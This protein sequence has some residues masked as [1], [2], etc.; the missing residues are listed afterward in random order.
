MLCM[1]VTILRLTMVLEIVMLA[2][3]LWRGLYRVVPCFTFYIFCCLVEPLPA[4]HVYRHGVGNEYYLTYYAI[5]LFNVALSL[6]CIVECCNKGYLR[7]ISIS[8]CLYLCLKFY[9]YELMVRGLVADA[10]RVH[11]ELRFPNIA[12]YVMWSLLVWGYDVFAP[13]SIREVINIMGHDKKHPD[14]KPKPKPQPDDQPGDPGDPGL[15]P[16]PPPTH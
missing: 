10:V 13:Q 9:G 7:S 16:P 6:V 1:D 12:C 11:G 2:G 8:M 15:P 3:L 4:M 5:D 14:P